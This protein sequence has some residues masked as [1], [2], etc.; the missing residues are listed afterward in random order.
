MLNS[1]IFIYLLCIGSQSLSPEIRSNRVVSCNDHSGCSH[2]GFQQLSSFS[3]INNLV[4]SI[5]RP[6]VPE[7]SRRWHYTTILSLIFV[8]WTLFILVPTLTVVV[9]L[10]SRWHLSPYVVD[11][12]TYLSISSVS[13]SISPFLV[14]YRVD[15]EDAYFGIVI[16]FFFGWVI[17][18]Y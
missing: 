15:R 9:S 10:F 17:F 3:W 12:S 18:I 14:C 16:R 1:I 13:L 7:W 8:F 6:V 11:S 5:C 2:W 4:C